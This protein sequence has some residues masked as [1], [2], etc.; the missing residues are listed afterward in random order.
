M[1]TV[2]QSAYNSPGK[3][4]TNTA[5]LS[6]S[7]TPGRILIAALSVDKGGRGTAPTVSS[8]WDLIET[9]VEDSINGALAWRYADGSAHSVTFTYRNARDSAAIIMELDE[10]ALVPK[11]TGV[12]PSPADDITRTTLSLN[13]GTSTGAGFAV[14]LAGVDT[15]ASSQMN[16]STYTNSEFTKQGDGSAFVSGDTAAIAPSGN[17]V[18]AIV[19]LRDVSASETVQTTFTS[20][21]NDQSFL[22]LAS[23][24]P[25]ATPA[26]TVVHVWSGKVTTTSAWVRGK[27]SDGASVRLAVDTDPAFSAPTYFGP[28]APTVDNMVSIEATGLTA[29]TVYHY[30]LEIDSDLRTDAAGKFRT[31]P[32]GSA[33][34]TFA[35][36][37]CAGQGA[38]TTVS[39]GVS[40]HAVFDTIRALDPA[41]FIH[42]GDIHY[43]DLGVGS[44][45]AFREAYDDILTFNGTEG[46][47]ARQGKLFRNVPIAYTWDDHDYT[48]NSSSGDN[49]Q[50]PSARFVYRERVP[51][52]ELPAQNWGPGGEGDGAIYQTWVCGRVRFVLT[53]ARSVR[54]SVTKVVHGA[55]QEAWLLNILTT[56]TEPVICWINSFPWIA[57]TVTSSDNWGGF[58]TERQR[59]ADAIDATPGL[60]GR[61]FMLSG[62][63]HGIA[64]DDGTNNQ[65]GGFPVYQFAAMDASGSVKGG[66]YSY[67]TQAG[68]DGQY[69]V[70]EVEDAG[71]TITVTGTGYQMSN[72]VMSHSFTVNLSTTTHNPGWHYYDYGAEDWVPVGGTVN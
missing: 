30:A 26:A 33:S 27:V 21:T 22:I 11:L 57:P 18:G 51:H 14:A 38:G 1:V 29:D 65:W 66:P 46:L 19:G 13:I 49:T 70:V 31:F 3:V 9:Y 58:N 35:A 40:N 68:G 12:F 48:G 24:E 42:M 71:S 41:F 45:A 59:I 4:T 7:T 17:G 32:S 50:S 43:R 44:L 10:T 54:N 72:E 34:F 63:M 67:G 62:D 25:E 20:A 37:S 61:L 39:D 15:I 69:G 2:I 47:N 60:S 23:F 16:L 56:A 5:T 28:D 64:I 6:N 52:Y 55:E 53:D 36:A 8:G